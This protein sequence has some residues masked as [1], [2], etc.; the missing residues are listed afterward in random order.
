MLNFVTNFTQ[1][2]AIGKKVHDLLILWLLPP[3]VG[4][5]I[6]ENFSGGEEGG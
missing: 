1:K 2:E 5:R 6:T 3:A 4:V